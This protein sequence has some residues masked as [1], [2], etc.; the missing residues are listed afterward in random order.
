MA[1]A[2]M[3]DIRLR[4]KSVES[5]MQ[6][7]KAM[8][9]VA[10]SKLRRARERLENSRPYFDQVYSTMSSIVRANKEFS[11]VYLRTRGGKKA[12]YVVIAG[13]RG[14]AG[15]YNVNVLK[16]AVSIMEG[17]EPLV[18]PLGRKSADYFTKRDYK[19]LKAPE[20]VV[21]SIGLSDCFE[22][23]RLLCDRYRKGEFD[24]LYFVYSGFVSMITQQPA[25]RKILPLHFENGSGTVT[26]LMTYDPSAEDVFE[27]ITPQYI[28][29]LLY[30]A[31]CESYAS[32]QGAR[33]AAMESA[34]DNAEEMIG[35]LE[36]VYNRARQAAIT[37]EISEIV[38]G[39]NAQ[40]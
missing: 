38:G 8:E 16:Y 27:L 39:A 28:A 30:G 18:V 21:E 35:E 2:N 31:V 22:L 36:L 7:T 34:S 14:L 4:I 20:Q 26:N 13:D 12:C 10:S 9:L 19:T 32:E 37:Q 25:E 24:E 40:A 1:G 11:S 15:G 17:R 29:G 5:T 33:R 3:K 23:A 6:I